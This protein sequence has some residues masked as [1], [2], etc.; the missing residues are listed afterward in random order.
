MHGCLLAGVQV[1]SSIVTM[2][3]HHT[4]DQGM[5]SISTSASAFSSY[6]REA[7][8]QRLTHTEALQATD[9]FSKELGYVVTISDVL[10]CLEQLQAQPSRHEHRQNS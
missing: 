3:Q 9:A 6:S 5:M 2:H 10:A 7:V 4:E 1:L 8:H